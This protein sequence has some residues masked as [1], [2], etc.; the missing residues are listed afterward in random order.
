MGRPTSERKDK[1]VKLR[2]SE[3]LYEEIV[4]RG[5]NVS[6]TIREMIKRDIVPRKEISAQNNV[7]QKNEE[8]L[9]RLSQNGAAYG[10]S[11]ERLAEMLMDSMDSGKI[12]YEN[13]EF[14]AEEKYDLSKLEEECRIK[15]VTVEKVIASMTQ[16]V[17]RM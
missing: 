16:M 5:N 12:I 11:G 17:G 4:K 13:G 2:L 9:H 6:E 15:G 3:G 10:L 1:T 8:Y 14:R 7:P